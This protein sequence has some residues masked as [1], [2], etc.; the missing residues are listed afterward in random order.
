[1]AE[2]QEKTKLRIA[3]ICDPIG[4]NKSGV[5]VSTLRFGKLLK[6]RG[7][8]VIFVGAK[9]HE[10]KDHSHHDGIKAYRYFGI[11]IPKGGGWHLAFPTVKE[12]KK[13]FQEEKINIVH[14]ILPM[15]GAVVAI[16]AAR[17]L[18]IKIVAHSHSQPENLFM[19][20]PN[21]IR[22]TLNNL[23]NRY[24]AWTYNKAESLIYPSEM[25]RSLLDKLSKKDQPSTV[26]SNG[27]NLNHF[28]PMEVGN[29][30]ER[31]KIP[32]DK[33]KLLFVGRLFPEKSVDTL[34]KAMPQIIKKNPN[35]HLMLTGGGH[36]RSKLEKLVASLKMEEH[37]TFLGLV[38]EEDKIL[39]F[40]A[41]DIF[42]LP[43][44]AE[45]EG[46][47]V[48]EAMACGKP[49]IISDAEMSASR[50]FVDGNGFLFKTLDHRHLAEQALKL[51]TNKDLRKKMGEV[52]LEKIKNY[53]I[54][55]SVEM[56]EDVYYRALG[57]RP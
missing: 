15:S 8:H 42:V 26:I 16:K 34:I 21:I 39:A 20:M 31:F 28:K 22:P 7:H 27:I 18:D 10:H 32:K 4:E 19:E 29:F 14:I 37:I 33:I 13:V 38:S 54:N 53:D 11:P 44:L 45:L 5:V 6:E 2:M 1:M 55:K 3:M 49:I 17:A 40:N 46:M 36:L 12:L 43:S 48:L 47:V 35:T 25:A 24:L 56:L 52:S 57:S 50:F 30:Y 9:N 51:I 23:W 41:S